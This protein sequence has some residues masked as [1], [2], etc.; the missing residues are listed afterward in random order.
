M[1]TRLA[2]V[3]MLF[4]G[5]PLAGA[6]AADRIE[7]GFGHTNEDSYRFGRFSGITERGMIPWVSLALEGDRHFDWSLTAEDVGGD[8]IRL[9]LEA[10]GSLGTITLNYSE[11]PF[12]Q[13]RDGCSPFQS[14]AGNTWDLPAA[15]LVSGDTTDTIT[16]LDTILEPIDIKRQ[17]KHVEIG[18]RTVIRDDWQFTVDYDRQA[19]EGLRPMGA[20]I[21][22]NGGNS[23][24]ALITSQIDHHTDRIELSLARGSSAGAFGLT[25]LGSWFENDTQPLTW[26]NPFAAASGWSAG[27]GW[28]D[29]TGQLSLEP[30][31]EAHQLRFFGAHAFS[32]RTR[33]TIDVSIGRMRQDE[34]LLPYTINDALDVP[35][36]L[37][38]HSLEGEIRT[39]VADARFSASPTAGLTLDAALRLDDRD[40][41]TARDLWLPVDGDSTGQVS[42]EE[43]L[44]NRPYSYR[45]LLAS[46]DART[47]IS[48]SVRLNA[49]Y[50]WER[51]E[52]D[53]SEID[54]SE[55]HTFT[56]GIR[57][58][59]PSSA[60]VSLDVD[61]TERDTTPY[62]GNRP[63]LLK[64]VPGSQDQGEFENHPLLR[65]YNEAE[66][67]SHQLRARVD[68]PV[69]L[70]SSFGAS[71]SWRVD[72][73]ADG[74][75]GLDRADFLSTGADFMHAPSDYWSFSAIVH[76]DLVEQDQAGRSFTFL[77]AQIN[78]PARNWWHAHTDRFVTAQL[79]AEGQDVMLLPG[80]SAN[81]KVEGGVSAAKSEMDTRTG[82]ALA[83]LPLPD[84][85]TRQRFARLSLTHGNLTV[86]FSRE[87]F[88]SED[89]RL[90]GVS[91]DTS[92]RVLLTGE[93]SPRYAV[94]W[95]GITWRYN[96]SP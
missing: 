34:A 75:F 1:S 17:R 37:P 91:V 7:L 39:L 83:S 38:R 51:I 9:G 73:Y 45:S 42:R 60:I 65:K 31:N 14:A 92:P 47:R 12:Y 81:L 80:W 66:R 78:D 4:A 76:F 58:S 16:D 56:G 11:L 27:V 95:T 61:L 93:Q 53:F 79:I 8:T 85:R 86:F 68:W 54:A 36:S 15:W 94:T 59:L 88:D 10:T 74:F 63:F 55:E 29:G 21:G 26:R 13:F 67:R 48:R 90:N 82:E 43:G 33:G 6:H 40:N 84:A 96:L 5:L 52:R 28:P 41:E 44:I 30:D 70:H 35:F 50:R 87:L 24:A 2:R 3:V 89:V 18:W 72:D 22:F 23:R 25:Y 62:V 49:G 46:L 71:L 57:L 20:S 32:H 77:P 19:T 64:H 69:D